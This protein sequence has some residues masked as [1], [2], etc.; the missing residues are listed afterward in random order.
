MP[1]HAARD[2]VQPSAMHDWHGMADV[3]ASP[4]H[5]A[6]HIVVTHTA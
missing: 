1:L 6:W 2:G 3:P 5:C 4:E